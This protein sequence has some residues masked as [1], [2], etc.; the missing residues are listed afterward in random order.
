MDLPITDTQL[1]LQSIEQKYK[2]HVKQLQKMLQDA[3][4]KL[5][6]QFK[7]IAQMQIEYNYCMELLE[8]NVYIP[9]S[10]DIVDLA[11]AKFINKEHEEGNIRIVFVRES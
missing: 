5:A 4:D 9:K 1:Q 2:D 10:Q 8:S 7:Y 6:V 11:L 3:N